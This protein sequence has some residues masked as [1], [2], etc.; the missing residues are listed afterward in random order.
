MRAVDSASACSG[1]PR[2]SI[3]PAS[4]D[5]SSRDSS[6]PRRSRGRSARPSFAQT[7]LLGTFV[8]R[9][10]AG[11]PDEQLLAIRE[12][13]V[14][15]IGTIRTILGLESFDENLGTLGQRVLRPTATQQRIRCAAFNHPALD[16][17]RRWILHVDV[18]PRVRVDPF[19]LHYGAAQLHRAL[20]IELGRK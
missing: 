18:D 9:A 6:K 16:L 19:H 3:A 14:A 5:R 1:T 20:G 4:S 17:A 10:R 15:A 8:R 13:D 2:T 11:R 12:R 7:L